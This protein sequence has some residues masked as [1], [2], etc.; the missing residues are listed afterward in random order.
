VLTNQAWSFSVAEAARALGVEHFSV[1]NDFTAVSLSLDYLPAEALTPVGPP[2]PAAGFGEARA[3]GVLGPGTGLGVGGLLRAGACAVPLVSE[4]GHVSFAPSDALEV[5]I[6]RVLLA[7]FGRLSNERLLSGP[8]LRHLY[9]ALAVVRGQPAAVLSAADITRHALAD[10]DALCREAL[11]RFCAILG[12]VA[13]DLALTLWAEAIFIA[14]GVVPRFTGFLAA[15][16]FRARF[17]DKGRFAAHMR[18]VPS[19]VITDANPGLLGAAV[20]L[21]R[22]SA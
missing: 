3:L 15:S 21:M 2:A 7:R 4:G 8:G 18:S 10:S 1:I 17:E 13:G 14:G 11:E 12:S 16:R 20:Y 22:Q 9:E 6:A 19:L 5:E